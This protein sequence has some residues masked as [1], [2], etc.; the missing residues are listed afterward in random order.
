MF[1]KQSFRELPDA[2]ENYLHLSERNVRLPVAGYVCRERI[3][4]ALPDVL[5]V[6][7]RVMGIWSGS[8]LRWHT[9]HD[10]LLSLLLV[11]DMLDSYHACYLCGETSFASPYV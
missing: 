2:N 1:L 7:F 4:P 8:I 6:Y 11:E 9:G 10:R 5:R 3:L